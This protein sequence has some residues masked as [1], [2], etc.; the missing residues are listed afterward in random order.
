[1]FA[2][3]LTLKWLRTGDL[4]TAALLGIVFGIM[5]LNRFASLTFFL[6]F[7]ATVLVVL[8]FPDAVRFP[9]DRIRI[10][11]SLAIT[12]AGFAIFQGGWWMYK[13]AHHVPALGSYSGSS[14]AWGHPP[15]A[16]SVAYFADV[17]MAPGLIAAAPF[18][19]GLRRLYKDHLAAGILLSLTVL[20]LVSTTALSDGSQTGLLRERYFIYCFPLIL[21]AAVLGA[22]EYFSLRPRWLAMVSLAAAPALCLAGVMLYNFPVPALVEM[23]WA[24]AVEE[25][26]GAHNGGFN[27]DLL[28]R[29]S[30]LIIGLA[31]A[32]MI[33]G[34]RWFAGILTTYLF[35]FNL[36][37]LAQV[38]HDI[39]ATTASIAERTSSL[40]ELFPPATGRLQRVVVAGFP[41]GW[42]NR[43]VPKTPRFLNASAAGLAPDNIWYL[44]TMKL[45]DVRMCATPY[46]VLNPD[47][48][49]AY[50]LSTVR[51]PNLEL[52]KSRGQ[53][54]LYRIP[55]PPA[56]RP[57]EG[58]ATY[59]GATEFVNTKLTGKTPAGVLAG[60][61]SEQSGVLVFGPYRRLDRGAYRATL[62]FEAPTT[63]P[64]SV[65]VV[66]G[67]TVVEQEDAPA[68][69]LSS[70]L[71]TA[72]PTLPLEFRIIGA[73]RKD[74]VFKGVELH[75]VATDWKLAEVEYKHDFPASQFLT[76]IGRRIPDGSL[77]SSGQPGFLC[78]GPYRKLAAGKYR[79]KFNLQSSGNGSVRADV[80]AA[81]GSILAAAEAA[82]NRF[83]VLEFFTNGQNPL[84]FRV[85]TTAGPEVTFNGAE[86]SSIE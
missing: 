33:A 39:S 16:L 47:L 29:N 76:R 78:Y 61:G 46:C 72:D 79:I 57:L 58:P 75:P 44:E 8:F 40:M 69:H 26:S 74:F 13:L 77:A 68:D 62:L 20:V 35:L 23:S 14:A 37:A 73:G 85:V 70:V 56:G 7:L 51:F 82:A 28:W 63:E 9:C 27:R 4:R 18:C 6:C 59:I 60:Q 81:D 49:G 25:L 65:E 43:Y 50:L 67:P 32:V 5:A 48:A 45:L 12:L 21:L 1:M 66:E 83:P 30:L 42:D 55:S 64:L 54:Q 22:R 86:V 34:K 41:P 80:A 15:L 2:F 38:G 10:L 19:A 71:F 84:E 53:V 52:V 17:F 11:L 31:S 24:H 3:W 36:Y